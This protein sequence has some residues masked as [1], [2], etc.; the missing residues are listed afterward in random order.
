MNHFEIV[1]VPARVHAICEFSRNYGSLINPLLMESITEP[2]T[3]ALFTAFCVFSPEG[4]QVDI[5]GREDL[6]WLKELFNEVC[7]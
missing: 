1:F 2:I 7:F 6:S 3:T 5:A 4:W